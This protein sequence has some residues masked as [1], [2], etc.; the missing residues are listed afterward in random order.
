MYDGADTR[1]AKPIGE[2]AKVYP[3]I[4]EDLL[5]DASSYTVA[6]PGGQTEHGLRRAGLTGAVLLMNYLFGGECWRDK[7]PSC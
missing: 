7:D 4:I 2:V 6:F 5:S 1:M 3:G